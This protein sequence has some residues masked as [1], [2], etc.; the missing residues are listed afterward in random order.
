MVTYEPHPRE[1][2]ARELGGVVSKGV[3]GI[4]LKVASNAVKTHVARPITAGIGAKTKNIRPRAFEATLEELL[5]R[6][7]YDDLD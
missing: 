1:S 5:A 6:E 3:I 4:A 2:E 7:F